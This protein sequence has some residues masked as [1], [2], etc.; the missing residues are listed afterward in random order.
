MHGRF[1]FMPDPTFAEQMVS[2]YE[3]LLLKSAGLQSVSVEGESMS[4]ADLEGK[5]EF[6]KNKVAREGGSKPRIA[7]I[8]MGGV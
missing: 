1:H 3:A 7:V 6:W 5:W 8:K 2:K 4:L